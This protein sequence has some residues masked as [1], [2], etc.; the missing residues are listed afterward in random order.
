MP[1]RSPNIQS[2]ILTEGMILTNAQT[3]ALTHACVRACVR[4]SGACR[5]AGVRAR[6]RVCMR[7]PI[8]EDMNSYMRAHAM[9]T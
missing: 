6:A 7:V 1:C 3:H 2:M 5:H 4:A 9:R 8:Y